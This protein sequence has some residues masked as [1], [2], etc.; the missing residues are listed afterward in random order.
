M[1]VRVPVVLSRDEVAR[2]MK[3]LDRLTWIIVAL[4][5]GAGLRLQEC[6]ELR[7]KD[8]DLEVVMPMNFRHVADDDKMARCRTVSN[9]TRRKPPPTSRTTSHERRNYENE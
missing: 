7:V 3:P 5:Y 2:I 1:P 6:L 8:I 4:L 9:G